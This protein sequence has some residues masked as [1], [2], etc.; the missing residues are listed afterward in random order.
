MTKEW[1][2]VS[3]L[4]AVVLAVSLYK[5]REVVAELPE[6]YVPRG[7]MGNASVAVNDDTYNGAFF[8]VWF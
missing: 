5:P 3:V 4:L 2:I 6:K 8:D 7:D 1:L